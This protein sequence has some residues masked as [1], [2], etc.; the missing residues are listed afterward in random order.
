MARKGVLTFN[1]LN[2]NINEV[3]FAGNFE[4]INEAEFYF[5]KDDLQCN[6][7]ENNLNDKCIIQNMD[8][9]LNIEE[10]KLLNIVVNYYLLLI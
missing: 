3:K 2:N 7:L 4:E 5:I 6:Y 1:N 9:I 8:I 10:L